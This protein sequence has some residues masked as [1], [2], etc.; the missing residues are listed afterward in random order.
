[1]NILPNS[2]RFDKL[3]KVAIAVISIILIV[4][5]VG[6]IVIASLAKLNVPELPNTDRDNTIDKENNMTLIK[7]KEPTF[8]I[9]GEVGWINDPNGLIYYNGQ[10]HAFFQYNP[11]DINWGPMHWGHVVSNDMTNWEYLPIAL[12]PGDDCDKNGCFSG[13]ALEHDGK[14]WLMYTGFIE[15]QGGDSIRQVQCLAES[16]DGVTFTKHGIVIGEND[17]PEGYSPSDFRDPK[18]WL[19]DGYFWCIIAARRIDGRGRILL[20]KS[21]DIFNWEFVNDLFGKDCAG[22]MIE[23]PDYNEDLGYLLFCEQFQP[24]GGKEHLNIHTCRYAIGRIDYST[25]MFVEESRGIVDYGFDMYAPQTFAG[26]SAIMGWLNMWDRDIPSRKYGF[27]GMLT[28]PRS[29]SV[30]DGRLYQEPIVNSKEVYTAAVSDKLTDDVLTGVITV[31]ATNLEGFELVMRSNGENY[32]TLNFKDG[33]W[34]RN[35]SKSG[36]PISGAEKDSDSFNG[37][38]RMPCSGNK[39]ITLTVVMDDF[40]VEIFEDGRVLSS[41]IYPPEGAT[42]LELTVKAASCTYTKAEIVTN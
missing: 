3:V 41:T 10:Y 27:A 40:S 9:T 7:T 4:S 42:A 2:L 17:L 13:T 31:K 6:Y 5:I 33:E 12:T 35:R 18:V 37:I 36:D 26:K 29:V 16:S 15:N 25:G 34:I 20:Y 1:M 24:N 30:R 11:Y 32:T 14:L 19:H 28:V 21:K 39:E 23:C 22:T 8:H 38:R